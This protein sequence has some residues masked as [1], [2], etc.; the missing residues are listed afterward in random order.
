MAASPASILEN[1]NANS[2]ISRGINDI[3]NPYVQFFLRL[4]FAIVVVWALIL[5][6]QIVA[7]FVARRILD[8][9]IQNNEYVVRTSKLIREVIFLV[10]ILFSMLIWFQILGFDF[11]LMIWWISMGISL[12]LKGFLWNM[13]AGI[14][15]LTNKEYK[16]W[17]KIFV[18]LPE[19]TYRWKLTSITA[20]YCV[21]KT[22]DRRKTIIPN[23][24]M[25]TH[26]VITYSET[27]LIR[28]EVEFK[29]DY[30][31][32]EINFSK[33]EKVIREG[34]NSMDRIKE[35]D[36]TRVMITYFEDSYVRYMCYCYFQRWE[37]NILMA[38]SLVKRQIIE[39]MRANDIKMH[40]P[41]ITVNMA[42][43]DQEIIQMMSSLQHAMWTKKSII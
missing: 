41:H 13:I 15:I 8:V 23:M 40:Y 18:V 34:V 10:L 31:F 36:S 19:W 14:M 29:V 2:V 17:D 7:E 26:P 39:T 3:W 1:A 4:I 21:V 20:R 28:L 38:K 42:K 25:I 27:W 43:N 24:S 9:N 5:I 22:L 33:V 16:I 32:D 6:S 35:K 30:D 37:V 11:S 12:W